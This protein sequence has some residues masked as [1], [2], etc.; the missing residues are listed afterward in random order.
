M[1]VQSMNFSKGGDD[2]NE[3]KQNL[4]S[5]PPKSEMEAT[6][7]SRVSEGPSHVLM[8]FSFV[9]S[10]SSKLAAD[11]SS[12]STSTSTSSKKQLLTSA[13]ASASTSTSTSNKPSSISMSRQ[14]TIRIDPRIER[15][16][17]HKRKKAYESSSSS[18]SANN[19]TF[20]TI[21]DGV[22]KVERELVECCERLP[23]QEQEDEDNNDDEN[24]EEEQIED[25]DE[26]SEVT[27]T[28]KVLGGVL[29]GEK[30]VR[31]AAILARSC[32][33]MGSKSLALA[34]LE[35]SLEAYLVEEKRNEIHEND[36]DAV[37]DDDEAVGLKNDEN[38]NED[39]HNNNKNTN[40][41]SSQ[42]HTRYQNRIKRLKLDENGKSIHCLASNEISGE[43][44][45]VEILDN[46][47]SS[48]GKL[49][50]KRRRFERFERFFAAGG[51]KILNQWLI[52]ASSYD[53]LVVTAPNPST[54]PTRKNAN[55]TEL[56]TTKRKA[57]TTRPLILTILHFLENIPFE[58][59]TVMNSKINKQIQ[60]LGKK[61][62]A[63]KEAQKDGKAP[64][65]D[66]DNWT[67]DKSITDVMA[68]SHIQT[69]VDAVKKSWREKATE[70]AQ[71]EQISQS[72]D[73]DP[74]QS[75][76]S[77]ILERLIKFE[78]GIPVIEPAISAAKKK[79]HPSSSLPTKRKI[80]EEKKS[81]SEHDKL[82]L[83]KKIKHAQSRSQRSLQEL[84]EKL[85]KRKVEN[86]ISPVDSLQGK[87]GNNNKRVVWKDGL[88][89]HLKRNRQMLE[90][91]FVFTKE[92]PSAESGTDYLARVV[93]RE[94]ES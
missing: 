30:E 43:N 40:V 93:K 6:T 89:S 37:E 12:A 44:S 61:V 11:P 85:L 19:N 54:S 92:L 22:S 86:G 18:L 21:W 47:P 38:N 36:E 32:H 76:R 87:I 17:I 74:L 4:K 9:A 29:A 75:V 52:D 65:E 80:V 33:T 2:N 66:L 59:K 8:N 68:L 83:Q 88:N 5:P 15:D 50:S 78:T 35:R 27:T 25:V 60:K 70:K 14:R 90:E 31:F 41:K 45:G 26:S 48:S 39:D 3:P 63:I 57:S 55:N 46:N 73:S 71:G 13:S 72:S 79:S 20:I 1:E 94:N 23:V 56:T 58:K 42:Q 53:M 64:K 7:S 84:R 10:S 77:K 91:V 28:T 62:M 49:Q 69:A 51:L 82:V 16:Y 67:T 24:E 81:S 34:I